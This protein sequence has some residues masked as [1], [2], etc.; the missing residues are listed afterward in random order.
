[1]AIPI[2]GNLEKIKILAFLNDTYTIPVSVYLAMFNPT[3]FEESL[4][5]EFSKETPPPAVESP[6]FDKIKADSFSLTLKVDG[7]GATKVGGV[8]SPE[9]LVQKNISLFKNT[10]TGGLVEAASALKIFSKSSHEVPYLILQWG[11]FVIKCRC[12][13]YTITYTLFDPAGLP[14]RADIKA[15]FVRQPPKGKLSALST[16]LSP[17]ITKTIVFKEGDTLPLLANQEYGD[18]S[19]YLEVARANN[20]TNFRDIKP[21][22]VLAFP[23]IDKSQQ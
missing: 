2:L 14:I 21:G 5:I 15:D 18:P 20:L 13:H 22:T 8:L 23:P 6:K 10:V 19:L 1:M 3:T 12:S 11:K 16:F 4:S 9:L 17:D 7:T